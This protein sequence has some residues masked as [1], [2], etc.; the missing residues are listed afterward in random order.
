VSKD[1]YGRP[2]ENKSD[3]QG[4]SHRGPVSRVYFSS[5]GLFGPSVAQLNGLG[6]SLHPSTAA[7]QELLSWGG[8]GAEGG[9]CRAASSRRATH[10][11]KK[12]CKRNT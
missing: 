8:V 11:A 6:R 7:L 3:G 5:R 12:Q 2:H 1:L 9:F 4:L 10:A